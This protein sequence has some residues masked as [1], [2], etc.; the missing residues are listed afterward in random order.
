MMCVCRNIVVMVNL[1]CKLD[2]KMI[3][4]YARNVEY[5]LKVR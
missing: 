4:F 1:D 3:V 2:L 5:N